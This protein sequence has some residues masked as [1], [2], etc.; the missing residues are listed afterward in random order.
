MRQGLSTAARQGISCQLGR[1]E[2]AE[3]FRRDESRFLF[4][5]PA[6]VFETPERGRGCQDLD[7]L[8]RTVPHGRKVEG[9]LTWE[10]T[11]V[12]KTCFWTT[13]GRL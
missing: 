2:V 4:D 6:M 12:I 11:I 5:A 8:C 13:P 10:T 3:A 9:F 1:N 7:L